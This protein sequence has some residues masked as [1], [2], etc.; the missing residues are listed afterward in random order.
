MG[1]RG[2][3]ERLGYQPALDGIRAL[4]I[5]AVTGLHAFGLPADGHL[6][7]DLF[8]V[9]SGFLI[10]TLL[11]DEHAAT[12]RIAFRAFYRRRAARLMPALVVMLGVPPLR[13]TSAD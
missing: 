5:T 13:W 1:D 9:L 6:G 8:F 4:A 11:L 10:T 12:G 7:V 3:P 2:T